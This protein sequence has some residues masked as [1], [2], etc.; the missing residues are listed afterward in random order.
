MA[1][2]GTELW[3]AILDPDWVPPAN[4]DS[5]GMAEAASRL[6]G[7][8]SSALVRHLLRNAEMRLGTELVPED[9]A[10]QSLLMNRFTGG[11]QRRWMAEIAAA[12][13]P[14]V[15]LKGFAFAHT[16]YPDP[17]LRTIG[18]IYLL[19][20]AGDRDRLLVFLQNRGFA[21][22]LLPTGPWGF[23]SDASYQPMVSAEGDCS[24][25]V[26]VQP[27]C[28]PAYRSLDC[29]RVFAASRT[30]D[31]AGSVCSVPSDTHALVLSL[32]NVAKDKF[33]PYSIRKIVDV[34]LLLRANRD[35]DW[36]EVALLARTGR[37]EGPAR[38]SFVLLEA[39]GAP[40]VMCRRRSAVPPAAFVAGRSGPCLRTTGRTSP[41]S[42]AR[43]ACWRA[44]CC[45]APSLRWR[46]TT[47][48]CACAGWFPHGAAFPPD[49]R[50]PTRPPRS[51]AETR[52]MW[53]SQSGTSSGSFAA[54]SDGV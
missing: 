28:Y 23:I 39:L 46:S 3:R 4:A 19:V 14:V 11:V 22:E 53:P 18:D 10:R 1:D 21:F 43:F 50:R 45:S 25:D 7:L 44:N 27:D 42:P 47:R 52:P 33:G 34:A 41:P 16:L 15:A 49:T 5:A 12:G 51:C 24:I 20:R 9:D 13:I 31:I 48:C 30:V 6:G 37:F 38:V 17:D 54:L 36:D 32:T 8:L 35:I 2:P 26:H 40:R 29:D